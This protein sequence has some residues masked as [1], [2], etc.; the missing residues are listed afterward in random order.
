MRTY[1]CHCRLKVFLLLT[2]TWCWISMVMLLM[3]YHRTFYFCVYIATAPLNTTSSGTENL[4]VRISEHT[5]QAFHDGRIR[6]SLVVHS[7]SAHTSADQC[8]PSLVKHSPASVGPERCHIPNLE[9]INVPLHKKRSLPVPGG[10][11]T[12][13]HSSL[14]LLGKSFGWVAVHWPA[15]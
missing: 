12:G 11:G 9:P 15:Q 3:L 5:T 4:L 10:S 13:W 2:F 1:Y 7:A 6:S 14:L 8:T